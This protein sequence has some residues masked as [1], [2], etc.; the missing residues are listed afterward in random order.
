MR[1]WASAQVAW[2]LSASAQRRLGA[3]VS[4]DAAALAVT[5]KRCLKGSQEAFAA[6]K[7]RDEELLRAFNSFKRR[8]DAECPGLRPLAGLVKGTNHRVA[9]R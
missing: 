4:G 5:K 3:A 6:V 7:A 2:C 1:N 9:R 8:K